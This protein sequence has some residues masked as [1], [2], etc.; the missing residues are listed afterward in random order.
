[1]N[2]VFTVLKVALGLGF[3]VF[4]HELGH[5]LLAKWNG[6]KVEK[7]SIGFGPTLLGFRRGET[8]YVLAALPLGGFVKMLGEGQEETDVKSSDPRAFPNKSVGARMAIISAGVI[9]NLIFGMFCFAYYFG[10]EHEEQAAVIGAVVGGSP[11]YTA[12]V[13]AGDAIVAIDDRVNP[14][15]MGVKRRVAL[16]GSGQKVRLQIKRPGRDDLIETEIQPRRELTGDA[17]TLGI[18]PG[19]S[20]S[21]YD[22]KAPPGMASPPTFPALELAERESKSDILVAAGPE[23]QPAEPIA[24]PQEYEKLLERY[25]E[26]PIVHV[27]ERRPIGPSDVAAKPPAVRT[28]LTLPPNYF[29]DFGIRFE[30]DPISAIGSGSPAAAADFRVGDRIVKVNDSEDFDPLRLPARCFQNAGKPMAFEVERLD[31]SGAQKRLTITVT[32][33]DTPYRLGLVLPNEPVDIPGLGFCF[34][35]RNRVSAVRSDSPAARAGIKAGDSINSMTLPP[36]KPVAGAAAASYDRAETIKID[37]LNPGWYSALSFLQ[38]R[39]I[40][41]VELTVNGGT[42]PVTVTPEIDKTWPNPDRGL[43]LLDAVRKRPAQN[44]VASIKSGYYETLDNIAEFYATIRGL[45]TRRVS[46]KN[47]GGPILIA[48]VA[49]SFADSGLTDLILFLGVISVNLAVLNFLPIPPLD[50]GQMVFLAAEKI[51]GRPLP[52][53][54]LIAGTYVGLLFV[55]CLMIFVT[56][57]DVFRLF[58]WL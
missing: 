26:K 2:F 40:Q 19:Y 8:E 7:F 21:V 15:F 23:G 13:R 41:E 58:H 48:Q 36:R 11:A 27:I 6:V 25:P 20:L 38:S 47:L 10:Q 24:S 52:D 45:A 29:V 42:K 28:E 55:L 43:R 14:S 37:E 9:M 50:G 16:S 17:P 3:V 44:F 32:P 39:P 57:Q 30:L 54:A 49:Y 31:A 22:F 46:P 56:Y 12:G 35:L 5:F 51:R 33:D 18:R 34:P 1:L 53:S 4:I